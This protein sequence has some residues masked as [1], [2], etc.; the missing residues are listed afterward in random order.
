MNPIHIS[1]SNSLCF[2]FCLNY[3]VIF[4]YNISQDGISKEDSKPKRTSYYND[5]L[6]M[7]VGRRNYNPT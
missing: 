1:L 4:I 5:M 3:A 7:V 6:V 2:F